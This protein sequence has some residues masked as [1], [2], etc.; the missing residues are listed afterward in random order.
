M[1]E[2]SDHSGSDETLA[3]APTSHFASDSVALSSRD[4]TIVARHCR[5]VRVPQHELSVYLNDHLA[6]S[7]AALEL[8][9]ELR[10]MSRLEA[11]ADTLHA[12]IAEDRQTLET[13]MVKT[14]IARSTTRQAAAWIS[15]KLA[16]FKVGLDGGADGDLK[17][18]ELL[19][20]LA[21][22]IEGKRALWTALRVA[23]ADVPGLLGPDYGDLTERARRQR[24]DVEEQRLEAAAAAFGVRR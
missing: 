21:L 17:R 5:E 4:S 7:T 19:E 16:E 11:W 6:G 15:G 3:T 13:L 1:P 20:A 18:L 24:D 22:G 23:A 14:G 8:L 10:K 2:S 9:V 12:D